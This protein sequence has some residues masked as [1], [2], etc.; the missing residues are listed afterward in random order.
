MSQ[1]SAFVHITELIGLVLTRLNLHFIEMNTAFVNT[2]GGACLH[3]GGSD[4]MAGEKLK[5]WRDLCIMDQAMW[6]NSLIEVGDFT[7]GRPIVL[8]WDKHTR[9]KI[10]KFCS[11]AAN[12][13]IYLGGEHHTDWLTTY[14]FD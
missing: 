1:G 12:V 10:G 11:I 7:Y 2:Y 4:T 14:P 8:Q 13:Q 6:T 9:L 3:T 5:Q